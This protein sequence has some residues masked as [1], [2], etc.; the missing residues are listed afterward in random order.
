MNYHIRAEYANGTYEDFQMGGDDLPHARER[1]EAKIKK[2][3]ILDVAHFDWRGAVVFV[4]KKV[5]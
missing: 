4:N 1:A 3:K 2:D 5:D